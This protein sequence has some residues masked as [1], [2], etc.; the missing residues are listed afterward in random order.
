MKQVDM[1]CECDSGER[2]VSIELSTESPWCSILGELAL[3]IASTLDRIDDALRDTRLTRVRLNGDPASC[4]LP[5]IWVRSIWGAETKPSIELEWAQIEPDTARCSTLL[6]ATRL[7][8]LLADAVRCDRPDTVQSAYGFDPRSPGVSE[9]AFDLLTNIVDVWDPNLRSAVLGDDWT[10]AVRVVLTQ[11]AIDGHRRIGIYGAGTH[12]RAV[13]EAFMEPPVE[14]CCII[15]DDARRHGD[16]LWGFE[17]V[18][19]ERALAMDLDAV[20]LSANSIEPL[21]W[22]RAAV[23]RER[24]IVTMRVH[25]A[26]DTLAEAHHAAH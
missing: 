11:C 23:F 9:D 3:P 5:L 2:R 17:I 10:R 25:G 13:G 19:P 22:E 4:L 16:R 1:T 26:T 24:G 12:T 15:D 18:S 6:P 14:I 20:V 8:C 7:A 21:L